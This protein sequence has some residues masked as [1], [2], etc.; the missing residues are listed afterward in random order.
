MSKPSETQKRKLRKLLRNLREEA[1]LRQ[2]DVATRLERPQSFVSKYE[3]GEMSL[4]FL[5][6]KQLCRILGV[7]FA[8]FVRRYEKEEDES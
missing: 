7:S 6:V 8:D 4:G 2:A 5:E 3:S 1:G